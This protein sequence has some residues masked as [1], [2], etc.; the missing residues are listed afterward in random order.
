MMIGLNLL[1][2][3]SIGLGIMR[4]KEVRIKILSLRS[5]VGKAVFF[6][7]GWVSREGKYFS[8]GI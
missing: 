7:V 4:R 2:M 5:F 1:D 6:M 3:R 8:F